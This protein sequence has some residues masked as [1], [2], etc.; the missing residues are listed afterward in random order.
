MLTPKIPM[1][2]IGIILKAV[3]TIPELMEQKKMH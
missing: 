2:T 3:M 1:V